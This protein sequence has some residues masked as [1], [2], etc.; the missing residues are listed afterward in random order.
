[1][2]VHVALLASFGLI[3]APVFGGCAN[4]VGAALEDSA[5]TAP[6]GAGDQGGGAGAIDPDDLDLLAPAGVC[7]K[8][9]EWYYL[10]GVLDGD[11][12]VIDDGYWNKV[13]L[14]GVAAPEIA[15]SSKPAECYGVKSWQAVK[16]WLPEGQGVK[17]CARPDPAAGDKDD[18]KRLLRYVYFKD[19][20]GRAVQL[21]A[22][23]IRR[24]Q[25]RMYRA[26]SKGLALEAEFAAR[27]AAA[28]AEKL[29]GWKECAW[30]P[31]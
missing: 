29:G 2:N 1:M 14:L 19:A 6:D 23:V 27:E 28:Q 24:G 8:P 26:F 13:R 4:T 18:Y 10:G 3:V 12:L 21:N 7:E 25:G 30:T 16:A 22:R 9:E 31:L 17:L 15:H 5:S 20:N 11:T